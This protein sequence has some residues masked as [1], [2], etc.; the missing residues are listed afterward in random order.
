MSAIVFL[1]ETLARTNGPYILCALIALLQIRSFGIAQQRLAL[2]EYDLA[3]ELALRQRSRSITWLLVVIEI[4]LMFYAVANV[5]A[6]TVRE[7]KAL[8]GGVLLGNAVA[9]APGAFQT[10]PPI[11]GTIANAQGTPLGAGAAQAALLAQTDVSS[12]VQPL[13][14]PVPTATPPGTIIPGADAP[15]GCTNPQAQLLVPANG[16]VVFEALTVMGSAFTPNLS[17]YR[18]EISGPS[19]GNSFVPYGG[20]H[21]APIATPGVLG[22]L[23]FSQFTPGTYYFRLTVFDSTSVLKAACMVTIHIEPR[24]PTPTPT[25]AA[26]LPN[27]PTPQP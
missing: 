7:D 5:V 25:Q 11:Q 17:S 9:A 1:I 13:L 24:P 23:T 8:S 3:R 22:Q 15:I 21:Q 2:A 18:F 14:T 4:A 16:Q 12:G 10:L 19:T 27:T 20:D 6:P 26:I